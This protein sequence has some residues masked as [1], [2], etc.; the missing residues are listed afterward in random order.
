MTLIFYLF[1]IVDMNKKLKQLKTLTLCAQQS[2]INGP[3]VTVKEQIMSYKFLG[4]F[5][6]FV[7]SDRSEMNQSVGRCS[8]KCIFY[9]H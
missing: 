5:L 9:I 4:L 3:L 8:D 7:N 1:Q 2:R 6:R